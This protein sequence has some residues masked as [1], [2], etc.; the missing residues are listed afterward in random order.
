MWWAISVR[1]GRIAG[2]REGSE[3]RLG[4]VSVVSKTTRMNNET[5]KYA[6]EGDQRLGSEDRILNWKEREKET[7]WKMR[8][9]N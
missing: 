1:K 8:E 4:G 9:E 3:T 7:E 2:E 6:F 5:N